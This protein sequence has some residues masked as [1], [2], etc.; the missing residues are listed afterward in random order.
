MPFQPFTPTPGHT[1]SNVRPQRA[2][3]SEPV[4]E[5]EVEQP[6]RR[7]RWVLFTLAAIVWIILAFH[8]EA[9]RVA[10]AVVLVFWFFAIGTMPHIAAARY[11]AEWFRGND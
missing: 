8:V 10:G 3:F 7:K 5:V 6:K 9:I 4:V 2:R 11:G 1:L